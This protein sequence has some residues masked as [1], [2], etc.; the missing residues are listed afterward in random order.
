MVL[1]IKRNEASIVVVGSFN[2]TIFNPDWLLR[3]ELISQV[4]IDDVNVEIIHR[5][6]AKF[7]LSWLSIEVVSNRFTA[8]TNDQSY[9]L[10]L[11]D[12]V[13]SIFSILN[14]T[15][16]V[17]MGMNRAFDVAL[18]DEATWHKVGDTLAPKTIWNKV[19]PERV[20]LTSLKV[21][22]PRADGLEGS[23]NASVETSRLQD[24]KYGVHFGVNSHVEINDDVTIEYVLTKYWEESL[25]SSE[26]MCESIIE[27]ATS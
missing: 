5:D 21:K 10:P 22:S 18:Q 26:K 7:S 15:P 24:I 4:E 20:G 25:H 8:R 17:Q 23:I 6:I 19:L 2:P 1:D 27:E 11:K 9:F 13:V 3:H 12:L 14:Q 16:V